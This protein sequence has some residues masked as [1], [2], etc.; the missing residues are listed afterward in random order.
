MDEQRS[1]RS[2]PLV[3]PQWRPQRPVT[4]LH[5]CHRTTDNSPMQQ[6][7]TLRPPSKGQRHGSS[8]HVI[9]GPSPA[10]SITTSG[11]GPTAHKGSKH[12]ATACSEHCMDIRSPG[13][14]GSNTQTPLPGNEALSRS[15]TGG[16]VTST[17][18]CTS[19]SLSTLTTS[20]W[21]A[22]VLYYPMHGH[23]YERS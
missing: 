19:S 5:A 13:G 1:S 17:R 16:D 8:Y 22:R 3:Q 10:A 23:S 9:S 4:W 14:G 7:P 18:S 11:T 20:K 12:L 6:W 21:Q 15:P 2:S